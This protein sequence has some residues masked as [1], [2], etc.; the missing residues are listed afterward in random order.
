MKMVSNLKVWYLIIWHIE[1]MLG[2]MVFVLYYTMDR[3]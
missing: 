3:V 2:S 1:S